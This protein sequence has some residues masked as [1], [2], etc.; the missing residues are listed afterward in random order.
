[1]TQETVA[2]L[3]EVELWA[4]RYCVTF[5]VSNSASSVEGIFESR[6]SEGI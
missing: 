5:S 1:M 3:E 4:D 2:A 6:R